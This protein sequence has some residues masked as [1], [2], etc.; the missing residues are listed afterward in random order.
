MDKQYNMGC[1]YQQKKIGKP[2]KVE[3]KIRK[4]LFGKIEKKSK[5]IHTDGQTKSWEKSCYFD[6]AQCNG[7]HILYHAFFSLYNACSKYNK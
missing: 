4:N 2:G 6:D 3:R 7:I 1:L 5:K